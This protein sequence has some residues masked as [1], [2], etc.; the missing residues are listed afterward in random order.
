MIGINSQIF[1]RSGGF[2]GLAFAMPI[3][4]AMQVKDQIAADTAR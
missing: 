4:V 3:D 1:S 2:Q